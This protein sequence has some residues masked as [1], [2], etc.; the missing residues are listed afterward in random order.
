MPRRLDALPRTPV[1]THETCRHSVREMGRVRGRVGARF[2]SE[3]PPLHAE[4]ERAVY[5]RQLVDDV[6]R[7][8]GQ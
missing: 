2:M 1:R 6:V 3:C 8:D 5:P 7:R 4:E